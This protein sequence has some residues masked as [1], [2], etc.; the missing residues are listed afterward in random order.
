MAIN[1][2]Q[3]KKAKKEKKLSYDDI[4]KITGYSRSTITNIFCGYIELPRYETIQAIEQALGLNNPPPTDKLLLSE[5]ER[6]LAEMIAGMTDEEVEELSRF[7]D[8]IISKRN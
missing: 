2:E 4:A 8:Y 7:V 5:E 3:W 6:H 1:I